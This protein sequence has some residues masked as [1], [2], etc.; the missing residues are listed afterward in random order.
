MGVGRRVGPCVGVGVGSS[1]LAGLRV[2]KRP[3]LFVGAEEGF[4]KCMRV[5]S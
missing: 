3:G 5:G 1:G 4:L 2:G